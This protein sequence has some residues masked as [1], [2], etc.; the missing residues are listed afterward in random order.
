MKIL[1]TA[2]AALV[3]AAPAFAAPPPNDNRPNAQLLPTFPSTAAGSTREA[4]LERLDPQVSRCGRVDATVWYEIDAAPDGTIVVTVQSS[5]QLAPSVR[6]F[7]RV[8]SNIEE[9]GCAN[10]VAGGKA[11]ASVTAVRGADY[12]ILVGR[13]PGAA[14][15]DFNLRADLALPPDNDQRDEA[16]QLARLPATVHATTLGA[17]ADGY[18]ACTL[19][20]GGVW[21]RFKG[22]RT[23]RVLL[24]LVTGERDGVVSAFRRSRNQVDQIGCSATDR[25]GKAELGFP[26][27]ADADYLILVGDKSGS[28]PGDFVLTV[29]AGEAPERFA[30][31]SLSLRGA[32][33]S[34]NGLTDVNDMWSV[35][36]RRGT[37][38]R[39]G[40]SS[41]LCAHAALRKGDHTLLRLGCHAYA[42]FTPGPDGGGRYA[43][44]VSASSYHRAQ[45]YRL[46]VAPAAQDDIGVGLE[47]AP[48]TAAHGRLSPRG[49]DIIDVYHFDVERLSEVRLKLARPAGR[50]FSLILLSDSGK[51][52][53]VEDESA[54]LRRRLSRGRYVAAVQS[55]VG[56]RPGRYLLRLR[57]RDITSTS[58]LVSGRRSAEITPGTAVAIQCLVSPSSSGGRVELQIDRFDTLTGW[59]F[60]RL[61]RVSADA[62]VSW[63][64]PAAGRWRV[65][66]RFLGTRSS[67]PSRSGYAHLLVARPIR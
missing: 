30:R 54:V 27:A 25:E 53:A 13:R 33:D 67:A 59:H 10:A 62:M 9:A 3:L 35:R 22:P 65:R 41:K 18:G 7:R 51:K 23:G 63:R 6:I 4:T 2:L 34:V 17:T 14:D 8:Q 11:V 52:I 5:G 36:M 55:E 48:G 37:T 31:R 26:A 20:G 46:R 38:Y 58:V 39:I 66:A 60:H 29:R 28:G 16:T 49:I 44:E 61:I 43:V 47:L 45:G 56:S 12:L 57:L 42:T 19:Y 24:R 40:F 21:Y 15:G 32:H 64:P 1:L 50:S